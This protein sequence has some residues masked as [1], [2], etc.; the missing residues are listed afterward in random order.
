MKK[1][2]PVVERSRAHL[3]PLGAIESRT[4]FG[5]Y[6]LAVE[7]VVFALI[8]QGELYLRASEPLQAYITDRPLQPL[9]FRKRGK[10]VSLNYYRVDETLWRDPEHLLALSAASLETAQL[11][12]QD[13][14]GSPRL[15]DLP[16][17]SVRLEMMLYD[18][19]IMSVNHLY[20]MG[21]KQC[22][23]KLKAINQHVGFQTLLALQGAI[24]GHHAAALPQAT[25]AELNAWFQRTLLSDTAPG[26]SKG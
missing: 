21:A 8:N 5:G 2:N 20:Q 11:E 25:R 16:N 9:V 18:A 12:L 26:S 13:R 22:W 17:L 10:L 6:A 14:Q 4:Q 24:T 7:S 23:L 1:V 3:A 15:K 19:G